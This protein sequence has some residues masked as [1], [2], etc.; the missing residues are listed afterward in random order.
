M[1]CGVGYRRGGPACSRE[2]RIVGL[3]RFVLLSALAVAGEFANKCG[4]CAV[5]DF[6]CYASC[7]FAPSP[8]PKVIK[9]IDALYSKCKDKACHDEAAEKV[10][11]PLRVK[12]KDRHTDKE[13]SASTTPSHALPHV[14]SPLLLAT[15]LLA[16]LI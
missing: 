5:K 9:E 8:T 3:V 7:H 4:Y 14:V 12:S 6:D 10:F 2:M 13:P 15:P 16:L 11:A 1:K